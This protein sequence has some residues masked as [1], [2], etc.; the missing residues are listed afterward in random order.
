M[1]V[2]MYFISRE[3][4]HDITCIPLFL[5]GIEDRSWTGGERYLWDKD[6]GGRVSWNGA[7]FLLSIV[8]LIKRSF[9]KRRSYKFFMD[10][11]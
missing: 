10:I 7:C 4:I 9:R 8:G 1:Y 2:C 5:I 3:N 6:L 11:L